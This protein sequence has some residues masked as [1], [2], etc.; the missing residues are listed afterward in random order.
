MSIG[1]ALQLALTSQLRCWPICSDQGV[2]GVLNRRKLER[3][4][5]EYGG[6]KALSLGGMGILRL[7]TG[8]NDEQ[9]LRHGKTE[10]GSQ[11]ESHLY[12][13]D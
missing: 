9:S 10:F 12:E 7:E 1:H 2:I 6:S 11:R 8:S 13:Y 3:A 5:A 4:V